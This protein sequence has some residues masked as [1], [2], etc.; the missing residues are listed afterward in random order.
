MPLRRLSLRDLAAV[1][2]A[3][4]RRLVQRRVGDLAGTDLLGIYNGRADVGQRVLQMVDPVQ[5]FPVVDV[6]SASAA[7]AEFLR[8]YAEEKERANSRLSYLSPNSVQS[9]ASAASPLS[10][11]YKDQSP[12]PSRRPPTVMGSHRPALPS[13]DNDDWE[14]DDSIDKGLSDRASNECEKAKKKNPK[15]EED[16]KMAAAAVIRSR[17]TF[18]QQQQPAGVYTPN[19]CS[20]S[21]VYARHV[22]SLP[23]C[24]ILE[25]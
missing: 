8:R 12:P 21:D 23:T 18:E 16:A 1:E 4:E 24:L 13:I 7:D 15:K 25:I 20:G 5:Q 10:V 14:E 17:G 3:I 22:H 9:N 6:A 19:I 11:H 2:R